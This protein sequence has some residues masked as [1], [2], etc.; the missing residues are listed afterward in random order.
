MSELFEIAI[1]E[2][3][4][5]YL[6]KIPDRMAGAIYDGMREASNDVK[7]AYRDHIASIFSRRL[8]N[9]VRDAVFPKRGAKS[10]EPAAMIYTKAPHIV[11]A[12]EHGATIKPTTQ[13]SGA[14]L[15]I[16]T[17]DVP[18]SRIKRRR[19]MSVEEFTDTFGGESLQPVPGD[20][21]GRVL[22]LVAK[23]GFRH[24]KSR[25]PSKRVKRARRIKQGSKA[26]SEPILMFIAIKQVRLDKRL[27]LESVSR[28]AVQ[29]LPVKIARHVARELN[30]D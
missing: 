28:S 18:R 10:L 27:N 22:Y 4:S 13:W 3:I 15:T 14:R 2:D 30:D 23:Q 20:S 12:F 29:L 16:P 1:K 19:P 24:T 8:A 5:E 9:T 7:Y 6:E 25:K 21:A 26:K 11:G 17:K